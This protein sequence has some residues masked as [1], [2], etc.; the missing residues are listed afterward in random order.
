M[1][2]ILQGNLHRSRTADDVL[3]QL[4]LDLQ[5]DM[6]IISEQYKN[7]EGPGWFTDLSGTAAIWIPSGRVPPIKDHGAGRGFVWVKQGST[8]IVSC[9][10]TPNEAINNFRERLNALEDT[11]RELE[12]TVI[13]AGDLN[14]KAVEW[15]MPTTN[16]RG[17]QILEMAARL[18]LVVMNTGN[19][20]TFRRPG[21]GETIP[22]IT[23]AS[24]PISASIINWRV[25][26][27]YTGSDHQYIVFDL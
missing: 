22:D 25:I 5:A 11:L 23:L 3:S 10:F 26:D 15:G 24:E 21:Y 13:V 12:G 1:M 6:I 17:R 18:G 2:R 16:S 20:S 9:Y 4:R 7:K 14:A 19:T 8:T 27:D